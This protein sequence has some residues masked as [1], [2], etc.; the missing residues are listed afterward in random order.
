MNEKLKVLEIDNINKY[1]R[2]ER[3]I[4]GTVGLAHSAS[5]VIYQES[6]KF[7]FDLDSNEIDI[8]SRLNRTLYIDPES[9]VS[10]GL[11]YGPGIGNTLP[12]PNVSTGSTQ[13]FVNTRSIYYR[14]H[15]LKTGDK[16]IYSSNEGDPIKI[17]L[18]GLISSDLT[19]GQELYTVWLSKDI[20]G[21]STE[22]LINN[23]S[24]YRSARFW[25]HHLFS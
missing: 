23:G 25:I 15:S 16:L 7:S 3:E 20:I 24:E 19:E 21:L 11:T 17:S 8:N 18:D 14:N 2:V 13:V 6:R 9:T 4:D 1:L 5:S 10:I 12:I 22:R